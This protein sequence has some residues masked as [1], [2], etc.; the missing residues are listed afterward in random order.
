MR[1]LKQGRKFHR[2]TGQRK[3]LMKGV[4]SSLILNGKI[5]TTLAKAKEFAP[6][7]EKAITKAKKGDLHSR[8]ILLRTFSDA[9]V[10]KLVSDVA[11]ANKDR[12][13]GYTRIIKLGE[14][15]SDSAKMAILE[16]VK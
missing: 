13:G 8:R 6:K 16:L 11:P 14:R 7:A 15:K 1:H 5:T 9:V 3:A 10:D 2:K 12:N 4:V